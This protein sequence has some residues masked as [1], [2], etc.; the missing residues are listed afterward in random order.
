MCRMVKRRGQKFWVRPMKVQQPQTQP[1]DAPGVQLDVDEILTVV[2]AL[3][4][5][6]QLVVHVVCLHAG[7]AAR[8]QVKGP[9]LGKGLV[10]PMDSQIASCKGVVCHKWATM[11]VREQSCLQNLHAVSA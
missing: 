9:R 11:Q 1:E 7:A 3:L 5:Y 2:D 10:S 8:P 4:Q 6:Q